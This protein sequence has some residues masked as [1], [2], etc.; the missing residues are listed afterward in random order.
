M[1]EVCVLC[2]LLSCVPGFFSSG[3]A[4][5]SLRDAVCLP[6][7][8]GPSGGPYNWTSE[9]AFECGSGHWLNG[10]ECAA[11]SVVSCSPGSYPSEC[12]GMNNSECAAC[13]V[14]PV[15][16]P[17]NWTDGCGYVCSDGY[18]FRSDS[19]CAM[20]SDHICFPGY[21]KTACTAHNDSECL[22]CPEPK[23]GFVWV[24]GCEYVCLDGYYRSNDG[25]SACS[26]PH[27]PAGTYLSACNAST[28]SACAP[29][30]D[31]GS[32]FVWTSGCEYACASGQ[33]WFNGSGC[34]RCDLNVACDNGW[35]LSACSQTSDSVCTECDQTLAMG[36]FE[37]TMGCEFSCN[38]G[39]FLQNGKCLRCST[40][41]CRAGTFPVNC[42][43]VSDAACASCVPPSGN[44]LWTN[45]CEFKCSDGFFMRDG[46]CVACTQFI[47]CVPGFKPSACSRFKDVVCEPCEAPS[48]VSYVWT[49][50]CQYACAGGYFL[51]GNQC[52]KCSAGPC[53]AG[54]FPV[55]CTA[56]ADLACVDCAPPS[57]SF[58]WTAGCSFECGGGYFKD[59]LA[60]CSPCSS[61]LSC[62]PG[63]YP[64][65]C[66]HSSDA[67]CV[68][69]TNAPAA[70]YAWTSGCDFRCLVGYYRDP[71][72]SCTR[73]SARSCGVGTFQVACTATSDARCAQCMSSMPGDRFVWT[74]P[75]CSF[76]CVSGYYLA[77]LT[78][79]E[80]CSDPVC[81]AGLY[82]V[83]CTVSAD[84][85]CAL[86]SGGGVGV[87]WGV[88]CEFSCA[89]GYVLT[90][91]R[92]EQQEAPMTTP[93]PRVFSVV[94][95]EMAM[96]NTVSEICSDVTTLILAMSQ[97]LG[98]L[99]N[100]TVEYHT[101]VTMLDGERCTAN[102]CPQCSFQNVSSRR[103]LSTISI[104]VV[105]QSTVPLKSA[106]PIMLSP[107]SLKDALVRSLSSS[108][109]FVGTVAATITTVNVVSEPVDPWIS[110]WYF[111]LLVSLL[112]FVSCACCMVCIAC[113]KRCF[114]LNEYADKRDC[115]SSADSFFSRHS[116]PRVSLNSGRMEAIAFRRRSK[117]RERSISIGLL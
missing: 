97:V 23:G 92:C 31:P 62:R 53:A 26:A 107:S 25:C 105:S 74:D 37:W 20:C 65:P 93:M 6:C 45:G 21:L 96:Q 14:P 17:T 56:N 75:A 38:Q 117:S 49:L 112:S 47:V 110:F 66:S 12:G 51:N 48:N 78:F 103:L 79:C 59:G 109:L 5:G 27:C 7:L 76:R 18:F 41:A 40:L 22:L 89:S 9:C 36:S 42:T 100:G 34:Q 99:S 82:K 84:S 64:K 1:A 116:N 11:C 88:G 55:D 58:L 54:T 30:A 69:C 52:K 13:S 50:G 16:G 32:G 101:D 8:N 43:N 87:V 44:Y 111:L 39:F 3:C 80:A 15:T 72:S 70:G 81:G 114:D 85:S 46:A 29:C 28:D 95:T 98:M 102:V 86:C 113:V 60:A 91:G 67:Q 57:G 104:N 71:L 63:N 108:V 24:G 90:S 10:T 19:E 83:G 61:D 35:R 68:G 73:C 94:N 115:G 33:Y 77:N 106:E 4:P 2:N